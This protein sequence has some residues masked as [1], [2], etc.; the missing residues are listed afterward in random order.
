MEVILMGKPFK[1]T[2]EYTAKSKT[3]SAS[4]NQ[5]NMLGSL[6]AGDL[7]QMENF[8]K[9]TFFEMKSRIR[10]SAHFMSIGQVDHKKKKGTLTRFQVE[11]LISKKLADNKRRGRVENSWDYKG[12]SKVN[13]PK[14]LMD[15][16]NDY[17]E[18]EKNI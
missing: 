10:T 14:K 7:L 17:L 5:L 2:A 16:I 15:N 12:F 9:F 18:G 4:Y 1:K 3:I 6:F 13:L 8:S 11:E